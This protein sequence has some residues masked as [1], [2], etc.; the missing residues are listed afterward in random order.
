MIIRWQT[1]LGQIPME[2]WTFVA[3]NDCPYGLFLSFRPDRESWRAFVLANA[4]CQADLYNVRWSGDVFQEHFVQFGEGDLA[5]AQAKLIEILA[6]RLGIDVAGIEPA[7]NGRAVRP[8]QMTT[9]QIQ[10]VA[11]IQ[12]QRRR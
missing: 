7:R 1:R 5:A 4:R 3:A 11:R 8:Q 2:S 10:Q 9:A 6:Q 12:P